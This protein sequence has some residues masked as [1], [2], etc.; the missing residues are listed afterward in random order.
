MPPEPAVH[1]RGDELGRSYTPDAVALA[2]LQRLAERVP[3]GASILEPCVGGGAFIRACRRVLGPRYVCGVDVDPDAPGRAGVDEFVV[4]SFGSVAWA[5]AFDLVVTNPP[6]GKAVGQDTT[7][8]I[9]R[10]ARAAAEVCAMLVPIDYLTQSGFEADVAECAEVWPVL[11]RPF[12]HERGMVVLVWDQG[13]R[14]PTWHRPLRWR[15]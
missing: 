8:C 13:H 9:L 7:L 2:I 5:P 6:F 4:Q 3:A 12:V 10:T 11:P 1:L 14:G 15:S